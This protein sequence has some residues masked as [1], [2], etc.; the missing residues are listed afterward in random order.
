VLSVEETIR[1]MQEM[2]DLIP[3]WPSERFCQCDKCMGTL[4]RRR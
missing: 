4:M 1:L 3:S 2:D